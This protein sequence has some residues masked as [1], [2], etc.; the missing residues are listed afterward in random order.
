MHQLYMPPQPVTD[1]GGSRSTNPLNKLI[2]NV[3]I[4]AAAIL[5]RIIETNLPRV[6]RG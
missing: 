3:K 6:K 4:Y 5:A 1:C 2:I